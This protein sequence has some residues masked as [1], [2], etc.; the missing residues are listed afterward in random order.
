MA[1]VF[2]SYGRE[3]RDLAERLAGGLKATAHTVWWDRDLLGGD[4]FRAVIGAELKRADVV[5]VIWTKTSVVKDWVLDEADRARQE[6]QLIPVLFVNPPDFSLPLGFGHVNFMD[7]SG[8]DGS[9]TA[10]QMVDLDHAIDAV[11]AGRYSEA[12][13]QLGGKALRSIAGDNEALR[14]LFKVGSTIGGLPMKRFVAG[15]LAITGVAVALQAAIEVLSPAELPT[16]TFEVGL[17]ALFLTAVARACAQFVQL[18]KGRSSRVFFDNGF[19]FWV[20]LSLLCGVI[21]FTLPTEDWTVPENL[22]WSLTKVF[23][24]LSSVYLVR[25]FAGLM[26]LLAQRL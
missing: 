4:N 19:S 8:W 6:K 10:P 20:M 17:T 21:L 23:W 24:V 5:I 13:A 11:Q 3:D 7:L 9:T 26:K 2:I 16:A 18:S 14:A 12:V 15:V 22:A 25:A 1:H